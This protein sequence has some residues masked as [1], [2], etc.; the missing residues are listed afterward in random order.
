MSDPMVG[1]LRVV[2]LAFDT[3]ATPP[4]PIDP[5]TVT[6]RVQRPDGTRTDIPGVSDGV[7]RYHADIVFTQRGDWHLQGIGTGVVPESTEIMWVR[8]SPGLVAP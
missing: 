7:G 3:T 5:T 1:D 6:V 2:R 4:A 8:V